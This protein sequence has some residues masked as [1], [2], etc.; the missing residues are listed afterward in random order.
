MYVD[1]LLSFHRVLLV[2]LLVPLPALAEYKPPKKRSAPSKSVTTTGTRGG[3]NGEKST[4][5][6]ALAPVQHVGQTA[7]SYPTFVWYIPD[8]DP[9][10]LTFQLYELSPSGKQ[11]VYDSYLQSS[12]GLMQ[13]SLPQ[14]QSGLSSDRE[15]SWQ[16]V[17]FCDPNSPSTALLAGASL[18]VITLPK[19]LSTQ[20]A[21]TPSH[22]ER[23]KLYAQAGFWYDALAEVTQP[24][25]SKQRINLIQALA[26]LETSE[27]TPKSEQ[28]EKL[29][30][31]LEADSLSQ[32]Q[33]QLPIKIKGAQ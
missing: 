18:N 19:T 15:Y 24:Q 29:L 32:S 8:P 21:K 11:L 16:V 5:F 20:L 4:S 10:P 17:L 33:T 25:F 2:L 31:I 13:L 9:R 26:A 28:G 22:E 7:S 27:A 6:T 23:A 14:D 30:Q 12:K 1:F 3:C